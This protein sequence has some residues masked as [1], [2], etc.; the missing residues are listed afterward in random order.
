M[1]KHFLL[2]FFSLLSL[3]LMAQTAGNA[4]LVLW[5]RDGTT[6][7]VALY[8]QPQVTFTADKLLVSSP[9]LNLEFPADEILRFT[10]KGEG[11]GIGTLQ[12]EA[13][14]SREDGRLVFHNVMASD[15]VAV[16]TSGGIRVPVSLARQGS[17][18]VLSLSQLPQGV[19]L[20]KVNGRT[21]KFTRP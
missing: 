3:P 11:T 14:Y 18:A 6:T 16:Y 13:D 9:V 19:Y 1:C 4:T 17:D 10:Y 21:S 7:D 12:T 5:H 20:L 2:L 8:T 15:A